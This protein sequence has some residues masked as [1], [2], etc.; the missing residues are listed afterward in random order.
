MKKKRLPQYSDGT[1]DREQGLKCRPGHFGGR[2][3]K[4]KGKIFEKMSSQHLGCPRSR[5]KASFRIELES[6]TDKTRFPTAESR[7]SGISWNLDRLAPTYPFAPF[8]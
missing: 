1:E 2:G 3:R 4:S 7:L 6:G 8:F 5:R